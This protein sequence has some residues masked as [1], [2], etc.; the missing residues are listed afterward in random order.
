MRS[1]EDAN[2]YRYFPEP[3]LPP[4][5]VAPAWVAAVRGSLAELP[6][7]RKA[8]FVAAY[9][10]SAYD[11]DVLV[12]VLVGGADFFEAVVRAGASPKASSNWIQGEVT[13]KLKEAGRD[14]VAGVPVSAAALAELMKLTEQGVVSSTVAKDVF[15]KMW[16]SGRSARTIIDA[17]GLGQTADSAELSALVDGVLQRHADVVGQ[18]RSGKTAV[19]GFLV[20][21]ALKASQGNA[22]PRVLTDLM[23]QALDG[24]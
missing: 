1:K 2:D 19:F 23:R 8:R 17:E 21:Q 18:Y 10:L 3:D 14:D 13:R 4:L 20:G 15:E 9:G 7:A 24:R 5:Q 22:N 16:T 11:A 6:E 12:R